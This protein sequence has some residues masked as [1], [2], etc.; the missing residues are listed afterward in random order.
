MELTQILTDLYSDADLMARFKADPRA[1]L[2]EKGATPPEGVE[3][4]VVENT[5][6]LNYIILP[7]LDEDTPLTTEELEKRLSKSA[8]M[9]PY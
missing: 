2:L 8:P 6:N 5:A 9:Y 7:Y 4:R 1:V 3:L